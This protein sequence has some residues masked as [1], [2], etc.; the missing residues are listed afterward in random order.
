M[1]AGKW[2]LEAVLSQLRKLSKREY[3]DGM[4]GFG[5]K[6]DRTLGVPVPDI[7]KLAKII[8]TDHVLSLELWDSGIHEAR[9]LSSMTA[10][11]AKI[12][13][14]EMERMAGEIDSWDICDNICG[15]LFLKTPF[16]ER[17]ITEWSRREEEFVKR[18]A[19]VL[20]AYFAVHRKN[21][22]DEQFIQYLDLIKEGANDDRN[23]VKKGV[24]WALRQIG[25]RSLKLNRLAVEVAKAL[26]D[27]G[28]GPEKWIGSRSYRELASQRVQERLKAKQEK[29]LK[30]I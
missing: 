19:F 10:D 14:E 12:T 30:H 1:G 26:K 23:Y 2:N 17:K 29:K 27:S 21:M 4:A 22:D 3:R 24:D 11:P 15:E 8:G 5:I 9:I 7:R 13:E 25:K 6:M 28:S 18:A 20:I 16:A